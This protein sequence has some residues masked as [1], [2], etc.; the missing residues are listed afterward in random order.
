LDKALAFVL[1]SQYPVGGW[2]QRFPLKDEFHH[3]GKADYTGYITFNDDVAGENIKFLIMVWQALG[4]KR[5][6]EPI[7]K[8]MDCFVLCQQPQPQPAWGLQ[9]T[10]SDLK[11]AGARTYEPEAFAS[12]TTGGNIASCMDFYELTGDPKF[13]ARVGEALDWLD[14]IK[15]TP[16]VQKGRPYPTFTEI[17]T[18]KPLY[19]HRTGSNVVNG[20]YFADQNPQRHGDPLLVVPRRE[21]RGLA[22]TPGQTEATPPE[23]ASKNSP[24]KGGSQGAA[25]ILHHRRHLGLGPSAA[26]CRARPPRPCR[27]TARR[28]PS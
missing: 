3:H 17:G 15:V 24:L 11:P 18:G 13:L 16:E 12:H 6:L 22:Q 14:S 27:P 28:S 26:I 4:D 7:R 10:V 23:V 19:I 25:Q 5:V 21:R 9:H 2:P 20:R 8:A 1:D